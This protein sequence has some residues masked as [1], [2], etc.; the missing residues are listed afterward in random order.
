LNIYTREHFNDGKGVVV[1]IAW[2]DTGQYEV[3]KTEQ[4]AIERLTEKLDWRYV[5]L[6]FLTHRFDR[7]HDRQK[8]QINEIMRQVVENKMPLVDRSR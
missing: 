7:L 5:A 1:W 6:A 8:N 3:A 2:D 4:E